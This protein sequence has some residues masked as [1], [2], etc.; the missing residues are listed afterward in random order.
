MQLSPSAIADALLFSVVR[1]QAEALQIAP[2]RGGVHVVTLDHPR[3]MV[4]CL[5][6]KSLQADAVVARLALIG[7]LDFTARDERFANLEVE[8]DGKRHPVTLSIRSGQGHLEAYIRRAMPQ[9]VSETR[10]YGVQTPPEW[11]GDYRIL[12]ELGRGALGVVYRAEHR[13]LKKTAAIKLWSLPNTQTA[14]ANAAL[15]REA[16]AA[17]A[18]RHGGVVDVY[19]ILRLPDGRIAMVMELLEGE[20]L[21]ARIARTGALEPTECIQI[22]RAI[23]DVLAATHNAGIVHR[24]LKP[25]N[26]FLLPDGRVKVLDFGAALSATRPDE[27]AGTLGTPWYMAPEQAMGNPP[28]RR[29]DLYSLG[30]VLFEM[31]TGNCP[32]DAPDPRA[33]IAKHIEEPIPTPESPLGPLPEALERSVM[34]A[35]AK[36]PE[37]R[38]Q[39][40]REFA[41]ELDAILAAL[42]RPGWRRWLAL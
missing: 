26:V 12:D 13:L 28:D 20:T 34:R 24:D 17:A 30:C 25:E 35:L 33:V 19:D 40:A 32:Y 14:K 21:S 5:E 11:I 37:Q 27:K 41:A 23:A 36:Y 3:G 7:G 9:A 2:T 31:L 15:L 16:R 8:L 39:D 10:R 42:A 18:T 29:S 1:T 4:T 38:P 6:L 22:A